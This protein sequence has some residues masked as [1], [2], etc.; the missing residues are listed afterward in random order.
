MDSAYIL[1]SAYERTAANRRCHQLQDKQLQALQYAVVARNT[2]QPRQGCNCGTK[3]Q[4]YIFADKRAGR[5][6][7][8][9]FQLCQVNL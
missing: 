9:F 3:G 8:L 5:L 7:C 4:Q 2:V 1:V 6:N